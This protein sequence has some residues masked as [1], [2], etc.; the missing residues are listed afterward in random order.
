M[1]PLER[2]AGMRGDLFIPSGTEIDATDP[3]SD[4]YGVY[5]DWITTMAD[6]SSSI[7]ELEEMIQGVSTDVRAE[8]GVLGADLPKGY[9]LKSSRAGGFSKFQA[10][11]DCEAF[12]LTPVLQRNPEYR[13]FD[14]GAFPS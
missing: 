7:T 10:Q 3:D 12:R 11:V 4:Y 2:L 13:N 9:V 1:G 8:H 14:N 6:S 5:I